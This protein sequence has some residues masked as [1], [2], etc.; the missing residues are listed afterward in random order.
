MREA[1]NEPTQTSD[2]EDGNLIPGF[3]LL[4]TLVASVFAVFIVS[5]NE[6]Q[7]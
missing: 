3:T 5:R 1:S 6:K 4:P 7:R 2:I